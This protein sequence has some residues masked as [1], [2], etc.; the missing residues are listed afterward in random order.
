[1]N[2]SNRRGTVIPTALAFAATAVVLAWIAVHALYIGRHAGTPRRTLFATLALIAALIVIGISALV[3][4]RAARRQRRLSALLRV[5]ERIIGT[6]EARVVDAEADP[7]STP[8]EPVT[9]T[10]TNQRLLMHHPSALGPP[11]L[12]LEHEQVESLRGLGPVLYGHLGRCLLLCLQLADGRS[13]LLRMNA[14]TALDLG[15]ARGRYL[16]RTRRQMRAVVVAAEGETAGAPHQPLCA[17]L[18]EG[19]P[20]VCLLEL[21]EH[22]LRVSGE[23]SAPLDDLHYCFRW[24]EITVGELQPADAHGYPDSWRTLR[25]AFEGDSE[26]TLCGTEAAMTRLRHHALTHGGRPEPS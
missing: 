26:L 24:D 17:L 11:A 14:A 23:Q 3:V 6:Y 19:E 7:T 13:F 10:L 1:M 21:A 20:G 18:E 25:L 4:V 2:C 5:G 15:P 12:D 22:Y 8:G 16:K 9:L